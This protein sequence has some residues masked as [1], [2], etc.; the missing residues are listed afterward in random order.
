MFL[1]DPVSYAFASARR[2]FRRINR[3]PTYAIKIITVKT[4]K[5]IVVNAMCSNFQKACEFL[6]QSQLQTA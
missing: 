3:K 1:R 2:F 5:N 4:N 6:Q